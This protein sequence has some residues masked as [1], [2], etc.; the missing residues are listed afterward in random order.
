M[1]WVQLTANV[2]GNTKIWVNLALATH[3]IT[4]RDHTEIFFNKENKVSVR[5]TPQ[6]ILGG[7]A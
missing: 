2:V 4:V 3:M 7:E 6:Q 1:S 5:E